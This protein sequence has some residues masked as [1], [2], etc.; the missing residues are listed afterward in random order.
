MSITLD[1]PQD[2][3]D[4]RT[5]VA[6]LERPGL[7]IQIANLL[8][9]PVEW[10]VSKLPARANRTLQT[11]VRG[12]L[13]KAADAAL[14]TL[15]DA[16]NAPA[17]TRLHKLAAAGS[18]AVGGFFG[19]AG[20]V[21]ELPVTTTIMMRAVADIA[22][23]EG[24]SLR[25]PQVQA[26]C[27][28]VFALGGSSEQDDAAET[29]YYALRALA[30]EAVGVAQRIGDKSV[31]AFTRKL[32]TRDAGAMLARLIESVAARF[33]VVITEKTAAQL[34]PVLGAAA[35]ATLNTLF[36][37]H[38]QAMA[39]GHFTVMRLERQYGHERVRAA[40]RHEAQLRP[41]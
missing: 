31:E 18:G 37:S 15:G 4:L 41:R 34:V 32:A 3:A 16:P 12:A 24:F 39:R 40:Y 8:G 29:G 36:I 21:A 30:G 1:S 28:E 38:Y 7:S 17:S 9:S 22:R 25:D 14:F 2:L 27:I 26:A 11:A 13:Y 5:A 20:L 10:A 23:S 19:L 6:L 33:G 35:G